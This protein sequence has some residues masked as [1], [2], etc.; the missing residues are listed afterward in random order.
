VQRIGSSLVA[1]GVAEAEAGGVVPGAGLVPGVPVFEVRLPGSAQAVRAG[2]EMPLGG[3]RAVLVLE[4]G[5]GSGT[6]P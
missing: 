5:R 1:R 4:V 3:H 6:S 2:R